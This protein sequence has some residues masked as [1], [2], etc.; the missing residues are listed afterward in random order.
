MTAIRIK[1]WAAHFEN[2]QSKRITKATW[3]KVPNK[4][5]GKGYRRI[6]KA[7]KPCQIFTAWI[8]MLQL[9]SKMPE[10]GL[11]I[12]DDG[13][14]TT[15]DMEDKTG[16]PEEIFIRAIKVLSE[17]KIGWIEVVKLQK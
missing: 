6:L 11:L 9:A 3:V 10:R 1:D 8:L 14:L 2:S 17:E 15:E 4:H 13:P 12:D 16:Y 5:D 7:Q